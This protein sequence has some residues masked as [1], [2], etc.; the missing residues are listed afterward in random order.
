MKTLKRFF[1]DIHTLRL[2]LLAGPITIQLS[3]EDRDAFIEAATKFR[4]NG[5][6]AKK[7]LKSGDAA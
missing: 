1:E 6:R 7:E 4:R 2:W 3:Q 5:P